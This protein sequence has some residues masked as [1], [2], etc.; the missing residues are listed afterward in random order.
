MID[1]CCLTHNEQYFSHITATKSCITRWDDD[2]DDDDDDDVYFVL[3][4]YAELDLY[5]AS[6]LK[7]QYDGRHVASREHI[8][9]IQNQ[10]DF[11][12]IP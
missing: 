8:I 4:Q 9:L 6:S 7:Q 10:P 3:D 11:A 12:L 5:S 1:C 2:D